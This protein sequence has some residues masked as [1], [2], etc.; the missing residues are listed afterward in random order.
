MQM[1][2]T[3][4]ILSIVVLLTA[5]PVRA[6]ESTLTLDRVFASRDFAS[7]RFGPARWLAA[8]DEYTTLERADGDGVDIV[9]YAARSGERRVLVPSSALIPDGADRPLSIQ[10]YTWSTDGSKLLIFTN[11]ARVWRANTRGDYWVLDLDSRRLSQLGRIFEPSTLMFAKFDPTG[12]RVAYVHKNNIYVENLH[13]GT[14]TQLTRDGSTTIINGTFD[15]VYEEEFSL[16][17]GFRWSPD[18]SRIAFWQLDAEGVRDYLLIND[19]DSL[20]SFVTPIQY[21][22]AGTTNSASRVGVVSVTGG[23][24]DW[25]EFSDDLR[26]NY[27]ARLYWTPDSH[28]IVVQHLNRPQNHLQVIFT[29]TRTGEKRVV[30]DERDSAWLDVVDDFTWTADGDAFTWMSEQNGWRVLYRVDR[31]TGKQTALT[32]ADE[33][34]ISIDAL[35]GDRVYFSASPDNPTQRYLYGNVGPRGA[36]KRISPEDQP[37]YHNY[38]ISPN[39][40]FA[41]HTY[42]RFDVPSTIDLVSLP[43]HKRLRVLVDNE[44]LKSEVADLTRSRPEFFRVDIG[45]DVVLDGWMIKPSSFDS[46][47]KYPVIF[48]VYGEPAAQTVVD[49]WGGSSLLYHTFL[50]EQGYVVI[51]VDNRGTPAPR[52][53][54]WRKVIYKKVGV[55]N[56][57]DQAA[58]AVKIS[59]WPFVDASR[60]GVWGWSGGG[61]MTLNLMFRYPDIYSSGVSVA[62]VPDQRLYDTIY[63][64]RYSG[65]PNTDPESYEQGSPITF[66]GQL[67]GNL[68]IIH[69]T[70]DDNVHF[71][72][73]E[74]LVNELIKANKYFQMLAYPN[75]THGIYEGPNTTRHVYGSMVRFWLANLPPGGES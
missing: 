16:R 9:A 1:L 52:G 57:A 51:S 25:F 42:S 37:G 49:R 46:A 6:Q 28:E 60:I 38:Q 29:D 72:G 24:V 56:S 69:G 50:A 65:N 74:R 64:E 53:R 34:V 2:R 23:S 15:W 73:T 32:P 70:G 10:D 19:T 68:L 5:V 18:G 71:Q 12:Q 67:E 36:A 55:V 30:I 17:D 62:P 40:R 27:V 41:I 75:R 63:Q 22:K 7:E 39:G 47:K 20:Y 58:A 13:D 44:R 48:Y 61:S 33:D 3:F 26:N 4:R 11:S 45:G 35:V 54:E 14:R 66:A 8:G 31:Q 59:E 21:P 43:D